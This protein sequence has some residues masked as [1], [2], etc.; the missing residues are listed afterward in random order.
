MHLEEYIRNLF[1]STL[2]S[3]AW[4][5][6]RYVEISGVC[7]QKIEIEESFDT[8]HEYQP[9]DCDVRLTSGDFHNTKHG[10]LNSNVHDINA[11]LLDY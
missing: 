3:F 7:K 1:V 9:R 4:I 8:N 6:S 2:L 10:L 11:V 5:D